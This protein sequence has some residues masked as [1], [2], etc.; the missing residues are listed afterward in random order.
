MP[1]GDPDCICQGTGLTTRLTATGN[2]GPEI[3]DC[4]E[5]TIRAEERERIRKSLETLERFD[6]EHEER[7][8]GEFQLGN[9]AIV[10]EPWE[11]GDWLRRSDALATLDNN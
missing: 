1:K 6:P 3:C 7:R 10:M 8:G 11:E 9:D 4:V 5:R 2:T